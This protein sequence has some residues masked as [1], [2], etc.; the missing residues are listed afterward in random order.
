MQN[1]QKRHGNVFSWD[2]KNRMFHGC[3]VKFNCS[4]ICTCGQDSHVSKRWQT[5]V[6]NVT[7][8]A[9]KEDCT[10]LWR[11]EVQRCLLSVVR[12]TWITELWNVNVTE[13][14]GRQRGATAGFCSLT[15]S[16]STCITVCNFNVEV[17]RSQTNGI[18]LPCIRNGLNSLTCVLS[19]CTGAQSAIW[20]T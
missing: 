4:N 10:N 14:A 8:K 1:T 5:A 17:I 11:Q 19:V 6:V 3:N 12:L 20:P 15:D 13:S 2:S 16:I 18:T 9:K 7:L